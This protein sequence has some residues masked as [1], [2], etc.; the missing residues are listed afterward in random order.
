VSA[1]SDAGAIAAALAELADRPAGDWPALLR[2]RF[3]TDPELVRQLQLWHAA[4]Q[5]TADDLGGGAAALGVDP[6]YELGVRLDGGATASVWQAYDHKL[7]RNVAIKVFDTGASPAIDEVLA[8]A[9]AACEV[10]SEHVVRVLDVH[11]AAP[12]AARPGIEPS[13]VP[14]IVMEL[15]GEHRPRDGSLEPGASAASCRPRDPWEAVRWVLGVARGVHDAHLRNVF[16]RDLK[17]HN[18]LITPISRRAKIADF[19]LAVSAAGAAGARPGR[20]ALRIA[21]TP[22]YLAPEQARGL[23]VG[24]DPRI[25]ADRAVL[26]GIDVWGLGAIAY[27]LLAGHPPWHAADGIAAWEL[28]AG[29][30]RPAPLDR[31]PGHAPGRTPDG[32]RIPPRLAR[33]V[34]RALA[35][36]PAQRYASAGE[37]ADELH[38]VLARRPTSFDRSLAMRVA[39]WARRNPQLTIT[40]AV[41]VLLA[42]M[43]LAAYAS[44]LHLRAQRGEL[45]GEI[46]A[47][48]ADRDRL[49]EQ[50]S[51]A[52]RELA[53]TEDNL[54]TQSA[55]LADLRRALGDAEAELRSIVQAREQALHSASAATRALAAERDVRDIADKTRELYERFWSRARKDADDAARERDAAIHERDAARTAADEAA[56]ERD[57]AR[58]GRAGAET[59]RDTARAERDRNL[60]ARK[61]ADAE[62]ARLVGELS[63]LVSLDRANDR[64]RGSGSDPPVPAPAPPISAAPVAPVPLGPAAPTSAPSDAAQPHA[65]AAAARAPAIEGTD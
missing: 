24:L 51:R 5:R 12:A 46:R 60:A 64:A 16:H 10:I 4:R 44:V 13:A 58:A 3:P 47:A 57:A 34:E 21:G 26:V 42:G 39:L 11:D 52:H 8:E 53:A 41:A 22:G 7:R 28:A 63:H 1:A 17:P 18:V 59:E 9:R 37:L 6:R 23:A 14:Y 32:H 19:G 2:A 20:G 43:S 56:A 49:A 36:D 54:R 45:A 27:D 62:V 33:I 55:S 48:T 15:V 29:G 25:P 61:L 38:A 31:R 40:A 50:A 30:A 35:A 65:E